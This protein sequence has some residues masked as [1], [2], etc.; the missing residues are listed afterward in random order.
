MGHAEEMGDARN[1]LSFGPQRHDQRPPQ[2]PAG[3]GLTAQDRAPHLHGSRLLLVGQDGPPLLAALSCQAQC[4]PPLEEQPL[5]LGILTQDQFQLAQSLEHLIRLGSRTRFVVVRHRAVG[6]FSTLHGITG[7]LH[8]GCQHPD[9][10]R[11]V[12]P[13]NVTVRH[14]VTPISANWTQVSLSK[15]GAELLSPYRYP[16]TRV[17]N[18]RN[19]RSA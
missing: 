7:P 10:F 8:I 1:A 16:E 4:A 5:L 18:P 6:S 19:F 9:S 15:A 13:S 12:V 14:I 3:L 17:P 11:R 2:V